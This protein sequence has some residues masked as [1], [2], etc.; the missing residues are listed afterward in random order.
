MAEEIAPAAGHPFVTLICERETS[1]LDLPPETIERLY[2]EH[3]A[4]LLRGFDIDLARFGM[5]AGRMCIASMPNEGPARRMLDPIH[6][7][8]TAAGG[9][10][11]FPLHPE[12]SR[13]P[14]RPDVAMFACLAPP[15]TDGETLVC[16][17]IALASAL[18]DTIR[19]GFEGRRLRQIYRA[20]PE[21]LAYWLGTPEPS[22][23][24]LA[25]PPQQCPFAFTRKG[26][27]VL[28]EFSR[29]ALHLP[30]FASERAFA[31]FLLFATYGLGRGAPVL[32][33][34]SRVPTLWLEAA[35]LLGDR[36]AAPIAW[37]RHDLLILDNTRFMHGRNAIVDENERQI[38]S[39]FGYLRWARPNQE[40]PHD[41]PWRRPGFRPP[42]TLSPDV[43]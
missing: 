16:D 29:P 6:G 7:I 33:D 38:A 18:P 12:L 25:A 43:T 11:P 39:Y 27:T 21:M 30:M 31:N 14:W 10:R 19:Q 32:D 1:I 22:D 5:F 3:G 8:Q 37:R 40:E 9:A 4:I 26:E 2:K 13:E 28:R 36:L 41:P 34:G 42:V 24:Q 35:R 15:K 23:G 20:T 17:G